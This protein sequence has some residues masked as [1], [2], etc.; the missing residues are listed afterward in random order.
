LTGSVQADP[1]SNPTPE[2]QAIG[3]CNGGLT[4][5][6]A[7]NGLLRQYLD[8]NGDIRVHDQ[9]ALNHFAERLNGRPRAIFGGRNPNEMYAE[10]CRAGASSDRPD[11][12]QGGALTA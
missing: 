6:G 11:F 3:R 5:I 10:M 8:K 7:S 12:Q 2:N 1:G 4:N 9:A